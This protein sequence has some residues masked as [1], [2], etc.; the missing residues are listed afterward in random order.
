LDDDKG[1]GDH[2]AKLQSL[3]EEEGRLSSALV[4]ATVLRIQADVVAVRGGVNSITDQLHT[5]R[6]MLGPSKIDELKKML[7]IDSEPWNS[8]FRACA[9]RRISGTGDWLLQHDLV[10]AWISSSTAEPQFL[11]IE[12]QSHAGKTYLATAAIVHLRKTARQTQTN[13]PVAYYLFD[14]A[15][16]GLT[17]ADVVRAVVF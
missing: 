2:L 5:M 16:T 14:K 9:E 6:G 13:A 15:A 10:M 1:V 12:A 3:V 4:L 7:Y 11:A 17:A 8:R